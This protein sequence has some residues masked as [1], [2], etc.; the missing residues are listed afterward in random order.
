M[1]YIINTKW[2]LIA[3]VSVIIFNYSSLTI[4][5]SAT[6]KN[7]ILTL[8]GLYFPIAFMSYQLMYR[9]EKLPGYVVNLLVVAVTILGLDYMINN[10]VLL[11]TYLDGETRLYVIYDNMLLLIIL[12]AVVLANIS[13][14]MNK[15]QHVMRVLSAG[16][17]IFVLIAIGTVLMFTVSASGFQI[18]AIKS[19]SVNLLA[20]I[21]P[22]IYILVLDFDQG[23]FRPIFWKLLMF[24]IIIG[25]I[26]IIL[27]K[28]SQIVNLDYIFSQSALVEI[29]NI[30][31]NHFLSGFIVLL[32][33]T[34][35]FSLF[36][37]I[38]Q[39][40]LKY[41][42][43]TND[44]GKG[45]NLTI[46]YV[47]L[48]AVAIL[49]KFLAADT[50]SMLIVLDEASD[51]IHLL[52]IIIISLLTIFTCFKMYI[53]P[54]VKAVLLL[55]STFPIIYSIYYLNIIDIHLNKYVTVV[56]SNLNLGLLVISAI[57][58]IYY[59]IETITLFVAYRMR[60]NTSEIESLT[61]HDYKEIFV[62][63]PCMN[64]DVVINNTLLSVLNND[65]PLLHV[66]VIDDASTDNTEAEV[67]KIT[68]SRCK[69]LKRY[70]PNAQI[71]KGE[72]LNWAY[73]KLISIIDQKVINHDDV[74]IAIID[75]DTEI[76]SDYFHKVNKV[77]QS[78]QT[79]TGLQSKVRVIDLGIDK[80]QDFEF[81]AIINASQSLR[82]KTGTVAFGG[83]GQFCK[84]STLESLNEEPWSKSL[85]EDF[86]LSTR[87]YLST[88]T[89]IN[90]I[91]YDDIYIM[92]SGIR[93]DIPALVKQ[94]VRWAQGNIQSSKYIAQIIVA[95]NLQ[96]KQKLELV[97]TLIKPWL[98]AIEYMILM[99]TLVLLVDM[100]LIE[101]VSKILILIVGAFIIMGIYIVVIN[102]VWAI[103]YNKQK[104][105]QL[106]VLTVI[107]DTFYLTKFLF[108]LT[109]IYPQ[110]II[111][112]FN[113]EDGWDKTSRQTKEE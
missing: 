87:L 73:H 17:L 84:L 80:S 88:E 30:N 56:I 12:F 53:K 75:A 112:H 107:I 24:T 58:F 35:N 19:Y 26:M 50:F 69:L 61:I 55:V 110:S 22:C 23:K 32:I 45:Y 95:P 59:T 3:I 39:S 89:V 5:A 86:D 109:Q 65:Y 97:S 60:L 79:I 64:E 44:K 72:A 41:S 70:K 28:N 8:V 78:D 33:I 92:Q 21:V 108:T 62:M 20:M 29:L 7:G 68:D 74:L 113:S 38:Y 1:N 25:F 76:E 102:L 98:M 4:I 14:R 104:S 82:N 57:I 37:V 48:V 96:L 94:R 36:I 18:I 10:L 77:F 103:L 47:T 100:L 101:G 27:I 67:L 11:S 63:I 43:Q 51:V 9:N 83:N 15:S 31:Y 91:Q 40:M 16:F 85:V 34:I 93:N 6:A 42:Y 111:R 52:V 66:Y 54:Q 13:L 71:G 106:S 105:R 81:S 2:Q 90:N 49:I 46:S 99:Y